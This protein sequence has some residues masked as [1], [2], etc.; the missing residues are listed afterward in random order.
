MDAQSSQLNSAAPSSERL[1]RVL[2]DARK[3]GDGGIG[4][5]VD[6]LI[7]GLCEIGGLEVTALVKPGAEARFPLP[8]EVSLI[9]DDSP[10]YSLDELLFLG[11]R[12]DWTKYDLFHTPH[13]VLPYGVKVPSIV[14]VHDLIHIEEPERFFYPAVAKALIRSSVSRA[15]AVLA[16]SNTTRVAVERLTG[17]AAGKVRHVP[18]AIASFLRKGGSPLALPAALS[19]VGPFFLSLFSNLKPHKALGDLLDAYELFKLSGSWR[20]AAAVCPK[21]VLVGYG[22]EEIAQSPTLSARVAAVGDI[23]VLGAVSE[24]Q[25]AALYS[26]ASALVVASR[27]E[28]FCLPALEA[29]ALGTP[30]VCRP[31]GALKELVTERDVVAETMSTE[32]LSDALARGLRRGAEFGRSPMPLHLEMYSPTRVA[33]RVRAVYAE[34][35]SAR[36]KA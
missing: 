23:I 7:R 3:L 21:L 19:G 15:D 25:L 13:Y 14:T 29:Q 35:L 1:T 10:C 2:I 8:Q 31:V 33:E 9:S 11:R 27:L 24:E 22:T 32:A 26:K 12:I 18:N 6:N 20:G 16:V 30:V 34:V 17:A 28:G 5:Y 36:R 4:V